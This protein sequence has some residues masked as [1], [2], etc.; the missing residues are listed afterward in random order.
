MRIIA[1]YFL[2]VDKIV[3][4]IL[5]PSEEVRDVVVQKIIRSLPLRFNPKVSTLKNISDMDK[6]NMDVLH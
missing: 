3:N 5:G 1:S 6:L 4:S 2:Q